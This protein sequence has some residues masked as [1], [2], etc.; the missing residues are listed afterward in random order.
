MRYTIKMSRRTRLTGEVFEL[1]FSRPSGLDFQPG[2]H[3]RFH[4]QGTARDYTPVLAAAGEPIRICVKKSRGSGFSTRLCECA[5]GSRFEISGPYGYFLYQPVDGP[6]VFIGTGTGVAPFAA[7]AHSGV[8]GYI[9]LQGARHPGQL[10]YGPLL[11]KNSL[12]YVPCL[13]RPPKGC[14]SPVFKGR[15]TDYLERILPAASYRFYLCGGRQMI[16]DAVEII[17]NRFP[18]SFVFTERFS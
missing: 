16:L 9:L 17:D 12:K 11:E 8:T 13:S 14:P 15:V 4:S 1:A 3:N 5:M 6:T 10:I 2:Q 7:F 18:D